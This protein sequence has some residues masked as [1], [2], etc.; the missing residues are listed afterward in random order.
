MGD[1]TS[2]RT[3]MKKNNVPIVP[4]TTTPIKSLEEAK[5]NRKSNWFTNY[6]KSICRWWWQRNAKS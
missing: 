5:R 6:D 2:A 4:G 3:L 1:K